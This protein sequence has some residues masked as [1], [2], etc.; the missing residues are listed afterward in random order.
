M[1]DFFVELNY[2][3]LQILTIMGK[4]VKRSRLAGIPAWALSLM[5]LFVPIVLVL[6]VEKIRLFDSNATDTGFFIFCF[7]FNIVACFF[8]CRTHPKS[9]W[10]TPFICN[11]SIIFWLVV[12]ALGYAASGY[13]PQRLLVLISVSGIIVLSVIGAFVGAKIGRRKINQAE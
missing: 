6:I 9:V 10:Y 1:I 12:I 13:A 3:H 8:I 2:Y 7:I 11:A 5:T 4:K